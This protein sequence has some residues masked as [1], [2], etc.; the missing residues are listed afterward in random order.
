MK[1]MIPFLMAGL[2]MLSAAQ[3]LPQQEAA[4]ALPSIAYPQ[5]PQCWSWKL[6]EKA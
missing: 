6:P 4:P 3:T 5:P 1:F 2:P